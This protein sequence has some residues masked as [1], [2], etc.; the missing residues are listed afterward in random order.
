MPDYFTLD[1][2]LEHVDSKFLMHY[3]DAKTAELTL[4]SAADTASAPR[5]IQFSLIFHGPLDAPIYQ[6]IFRVDH[7]KL[8]P[9]DL[10]LVPIARDKNGM[11]YEAIFNRRLE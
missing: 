8:G 10:F 11:Q 6:S 3:G 5:Q 4:V 7:E 2:F 1:M 9:L